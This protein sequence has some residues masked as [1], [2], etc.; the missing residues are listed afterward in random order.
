M[1]AMLIAPS[2]VDGGSEAL[3]LGLVRAAPEVGLEPTCLCLE[4]GPLVDRLRDAGATVHVHEAPRLRDLRSALR[5]HRWIRE[6]IAAQRPD[7]VYSNMAKAHVFAALAARRAGVPAVWHQ[8]GVPDP[9]HWLDRLA[10]ALP[11]AGVMTVSEEGAAAQRRIWPGPDV[12][13]VHPGI[14][15][16]RYAGLDRRACRLEVG[17]DPDGVYVGIVGRLQEWKGQRE[18]L[19]AAALVLQRMPS[20]R[21]VVVGG[22]LLGWEGDYPERLERLAADLGLGQRVVFTGHRTDTP[23][24]FAS[25]D[26]SVNA[27]NPE[28]FGL[29]VV[30]AMAAGAPVVAVDRGGPADVITHDLTGLLCDRP[31]PALLAEAICALLEAPDRAARIA[32][33]ARDMVSAQFSSRR[34]AEDFVGMLA[35]CVGT[36]AA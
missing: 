29:V 23:K 3:M 30:E 16:S 20:T 21:F 8:A 7:I 9:P 6:Q 34:M 2:A 1:R 14:D 5:T 13:L 22:A 4:T 36:A 25:L 10:S 27:S 32:D 11:A 26:V 31:D 15:L 12:S 24:W 19:E 35:D 28:P 33:A 18:F 17:L